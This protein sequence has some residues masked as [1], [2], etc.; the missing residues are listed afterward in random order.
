MKISLGSKAL[1]FP[2]PVWVVATYDRAG[3]PN[4]MTA[5]WG[6]ICCSSPPAIC[7]SLRK[8]TYTYGN[9]SER[10]AFTIN[11]LSEDRIREADYFGLVSGRS[12]D[13]LSAVG[14]SPRKAELVDA[15]YLDQA[16][17]VLECSL[18]TMV[19]IGLHTQFIGE[20]MDVKVEESALGEDGL[21]AMEKVRPAVFAPET[22]KYF[23]IGKYLGPAFSLGR[24]MGKQKKEDR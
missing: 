12:E 2:T 1:V 24:E 14:F 17:M 22:R 9:I 15:P 13:K 16:S 20:V 3:K 19:E 8:A 11:I 4:V 21:P 10:R 23:G 5:A 7:V 6:G 18:L